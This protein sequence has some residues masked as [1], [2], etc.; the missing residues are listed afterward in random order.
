MKKFLVLL[1]P[2]FLLLSGCRKDGFVPYSGQEM[3]LIQNGSI[4]TDEGVR[5]IIDGNP[6][7]Y[8]ILTSR[9]VLVSYKTTSIGSDRTYTIDLQELMETTVS[10]PIPVSEPLGL[11]SDDPVR[12]SEA[13]F[14]GGYLNLTVAY[15]G[16]DPALHTFPLRFDIDGKRAVLRL[17]HDAR[18]SV[19]SDTEPKQACLCFPM[20]AVAAAFPAPADKSKTTVIPVLLQWRWY[21]DDD[22]SRQTVLY[23]KEGTYRAKH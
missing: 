18:E 5:L 4:L 2:L 8:D 10:D 20:E 3:G 11:V 13:W 14:S 21:E 7:N 6:E 19:P 15:A 22:P 23:V 1:L 16:I 17:Y 9:R 12:I